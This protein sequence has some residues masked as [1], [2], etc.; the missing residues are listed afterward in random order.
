MIMSDWIKPG[1]HVTAMGADSPG[2]QEL[3]RK[4]VAR[5]DILVV[6]IARQCLEHGEFAG[7]F[8]DGLIKSD[9]CTELGM[10]LAGKAVGRKDPAD[11]TIA[12]LTGV[13]TQDIAIARTVLERTPGLKL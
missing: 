6:D 7:A 8:A 12:D 5:A 10:I 4:L 3:D 2:K 9:D 1:T 13:A 11:I